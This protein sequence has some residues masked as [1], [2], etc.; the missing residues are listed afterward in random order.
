MVYYKAMRGRRLSL[1]VLMLSLLCAPAAQAGL[2]SALT[3]A[4]KKV[5]APDGSLAAI[6]DIKW[7][8]LGVNA[9][10]GVPPTVVRGKLN[11]DNQWVL[12]D[13]AGKVVDDIASV[14]NP[15]IVID[16]AYLPTRLSE[17]NRL[18]TDAPILL[19]SDEALFRLENNNGWVLKS[20]Q[21]GIRVTTAPDTKT[22]LH[23]FSRPWSNGPV[24]IVGLKDQAA[25]SMS[26][27]R[28]V[29]V[30]TIMEMPSQLRGQ[31]LALAGP[32]KNNRIS[33][34]GKQV[35]ISD[36]RRIADENDISLVI[37]ESQRKVSPKAL[38]KRLDDNMVDGVPQNTG[39][40]LA[41]LNQPGAE[42]SFTISPTSKN[43]VV[44]R[45]QA[46]ASN[47]AATEASQQTSTKMETVIGVHTAIRIMLYRPGEERQ[48]E[49]EDLVFG[50]LPSW[51]LGYM[52]VSLV[53]GAVFAGTTSGVFYKYWPTSGTQNRWLRGTEIG[54]SVVVFFIFLLFLGLPVAIAKVI[55]MIL[56]GIWWVL[57]GVVV[58]VMGLGAMIS[59][60]F[61][62][63]DAA[64]ERVH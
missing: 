51:V 27:R 34:A 4:V 63:G 29:D 10:D 58:I 47:D 33:V 56:K 23:H 26:L 30:K 53:A 38:L 52:V 5:E 8:A 17:L 35:S 44:I 7:Q 62:R 49:L 55:W 37:M 48:Q 28:G 6:P 20:G 2:L 42:S 25:T 46:Q 59:K 40:F 12:Q 16:Q 3:K 15:A 43:Q 54:F 50:W 45:R 57:A 14:S 60:L 41:R 11:A 31:T 32:I 13:S 64:D 39:Q 24:R 61:R 21:A 18:P 1:L 19:R 22:A 9:I 36:L